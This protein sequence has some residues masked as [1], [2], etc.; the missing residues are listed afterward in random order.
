MSQRV[1]FGNSLSSFV[2]SRG[3]SSG[4]SVSCA[5]SRKGNNEL[6]YC[7]GLLCQ[8][9]PYMTFCVIDGEM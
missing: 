5:I 4:K 8:R 2:G 1:E 9:N 6:I 7:N 3:Q